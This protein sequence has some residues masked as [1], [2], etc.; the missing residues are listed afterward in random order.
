MQ[1][2]ILIIYFSFLINTVFSQTISDS[3]HCN[4][5]INTKRRYNYGIGI[6]PSKAD[7]INGWTIGWLLLDVRDDKKDST[8]IN[9]LYT[10]IGPA[11][12]LMGLMLFPYGLISPFI[13]STDTIEEFDTLRNVNRINGISISFFE[14]SDRYIVNGL[15]ISV[16]GHGMY[17]L[18]GLSLSLG[19]SQY[20]SY[21]GIMISGYLNDVEKGKG[22]QI[23]LFNKAKQMKGIQIGLWNKIGKRSLPFINMC[24]KN[25]N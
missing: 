15:Q 25:K 24:F 5:N 10:N 2:Y 4:K 21:N 20:K 12:A 7:V 17:K 6:M 13:K 18:N 19:F 11:Q 8:K 23:G 1:R 16:E 9:G 3:I 22:L 14:M